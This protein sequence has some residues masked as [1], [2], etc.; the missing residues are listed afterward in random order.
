MWFKVKGLEFT[1]SRFGFQVF[2]LEF[3]VL[4]YGGYLRGFLG[5]SF[6][7]CLSFGVFVFLGVN[8]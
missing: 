8:S 4:S 5:D 3:G 6:S 7:G 1:V 2:G